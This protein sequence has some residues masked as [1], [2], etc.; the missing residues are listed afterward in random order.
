RQAVVV[1]LV[2]VGR[3]A[4][5]GRDVDGVARDVVERRQELRVLEEVAAEGV[6]YGDRRGATLVAEQDA[7]ADGLDDQLRFV[8]RSRSRAC[9]IPITPDAEVVMPVR[10]ALRAV[11]PFRRAARA[12]WS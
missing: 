2:Q 6:V 1:D 5:G 7:P 11:A 3:L 12:A 9:S 4:E 10:R 8:R